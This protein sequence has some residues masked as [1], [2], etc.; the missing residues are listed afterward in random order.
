MSADETSSTNGMVTHDH[1]NDSD[2]K[3]SKDTHATN[4]KRVSNR[5]SARRFRQRRKQYVEQLETQVSSLRDENQQ[6]KALLT[7]HFQLQG[8]PLPSIVTKGGDS[9]VEDD[10][11]NS[12]KRAKR[13]TK[14]SSVP[15]DSPTP[16][17]SRPSEHGPSSRFSSGQSSPLDALALAATRASE[18]AGDGTNSRHDDGPAN[19]SPGINPSAVVLPTPPMVSMMPTPSSMIAA[20]SNAMATAMTSQAAATNGL[21]PG[22]PNAMAMQA[23][24]M[25]PYMQ[26]MMQ[27]QQQQ[28]LKS[29]SSANQ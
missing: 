14:T 13:T 9:G 22:M 27:Q 16:A 24:M 25:A 3:G 18:H 28:M 6:L 1:L 12:S 5:E 7:A 17:P 8:L 29:M 26:M 23:M 4:A 11:A 20:T 15:A 10:G 19:N 21:M 2:H